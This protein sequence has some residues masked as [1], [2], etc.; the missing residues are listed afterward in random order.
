MAIGVSKFINSIENAVF[1]RFCIR[2]QDEGSLLCSKCIT[3]WV[4]SIPERA[5]GVFSHFYYADPV[6]RGLIHA[7]KYHFDVSAWNIL[8]HVLERDIYQLIDFLRVHEIDYIVP[9]PLYKRRAC[10]RG[11]DQA[12]EIAN[13]ISWTAGVPCKDM[14]FRFRSTGR[15]A[16]RSVLDRKRE[17]LALPFRIIDPSFFIGQA[18]KGYRVLLVDDVWTT[19]A[20][21]KAASTVLKSACAEEVHYYTLAKG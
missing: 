1:P 16:E 17:M 11:F 5:D 12:K 8:K 21:A 13:F 6:A 4:Y 19:G 15:Q 3:D 2:C 18:G 10:E 7:W 9:I 20:T 14:L